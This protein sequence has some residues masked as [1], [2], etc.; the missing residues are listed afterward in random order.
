MNGLSGLLGV[1]PHNSDAVHPKN[2]R[3]GGRQFP[4]FVHLKRLLL[5]KQQKRLTPQRS[6]KSAK[7][8]TNH[9]LK[10]ELFR[11]FREGGVL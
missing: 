3:Y 10:P 9:S 11:L 1:F 6:D 7:A 4:N 2:P 8:L 5:L